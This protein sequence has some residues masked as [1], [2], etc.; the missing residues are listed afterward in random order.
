MSERKIILGIDPGKSGGFATLFEDG[1]ATGAVAALPMPLSPHD[2]VDALNWTSPAVAYLERVASS[3]Q[4][5]VKS[6]FTFGQ[7]FGVILG[8]LAALEIRTELVAPGVWQRA[9]GCLSKGDKNVTK[10]KAQ[11]LFP[12]L[13]VTHAIADALLIAEYGRRVEAMRTVEEALR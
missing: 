10:R 11:Q 9:M 8:V 13:T 1:S 3:P 6:A 5:G 7:G 2:L 4:M 12:G